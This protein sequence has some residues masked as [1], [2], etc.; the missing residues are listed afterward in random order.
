MEGFIVGGN[1][2]NIELHAHSAFLNIYCVTDDGNR[3]GFVC[4]SSVV[5]QRIILTA[6]HC[7][8]GC[9]SYS[10]VT[11]NLGDEHR[12]K[13]KAYTVFSFMLH[14]DYSPLTSSNDISLLQVE[15]AIELNKK[16]GRVALMRNPPYSELAK[17]AGWGMVD[18]S[19][20]CYAK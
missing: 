19:L 1:Y 13:G 12:H 7:L 4:G 8:S 10:H 17:V 18:V 9:N 20:I 3:T 14:E 2:A 6:A 11:V 16:T 5:N 15:K